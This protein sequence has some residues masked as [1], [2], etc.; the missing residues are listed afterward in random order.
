M[1]EKDWELLFILHKEGSITKT[2]EKLYISQP[3]LTYR[4]KQIEKEFNTKIVYRGSKGITFTNE[5]EQLVEYAESMLV[6]LR[7]VKDSMK[8]TGS[9]VQGT[10]RLGV[11]SNFAFYQL[12][13]I[14]EG[15]IAKYPKIEIN[16]QTGWSSMIVNLLQRDEVH[17]G[18]VRGEHQ[19]S[20]SQFLLSQEPI[21][22]A[23]SNPINL[24]DLP[25]LDQIKYHTDIR[26]KHTLSQWWQAH[27]NKPTKIAMEVDRIET[28]KEL[29]K[30]NLG[31]GIF[32]GICLE[33]NDQLY[34]IPL[35]K[36]NGLVLRETSI[37]YKNDLLE[38]KVI[39]A[40]YSYVK[41]YYSE[42]INSKKSYV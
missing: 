32:P 24:K 9:E 41:E 12:P 35:K 10:L 8:N 38:L 31:Y 39:E 15:F 17:I 42:I 11:S 29:V 1:T 2:A 7:R 19:W 5:G 28:A 22:I 6:E 37:L 4:I 23:S 13:A 26:L 21:Y 20:D 34:K 30:R 40:F 33:D 16:L 14:L 27:F 36:D 18:I 3:A 25:H